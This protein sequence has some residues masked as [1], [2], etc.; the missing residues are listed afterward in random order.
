[1]QNKSKN[2]NLLLLGTISILLGCGYFFASDMFVPSLPHMTSYFSVDSGTARLTLSTFLISLAFSQLLYGPASDRFGRKPII[3]IGII[4]YI[5]GSIV[6]LTSLSMNMLLIGRIVQGLGVGAL[7][8]LSRT[9]IQDSTTKEQFV[10]LVSILSIFFLIA[11]A[12]APLLGGILQTY[13]DWRASFVFMLIFGLSLFLI[14][15]LLLKETHKHKNPKALHL[16]SLHTNYSAILKNIDFLVMC[17]TMV[18]GLAGL[19]VFYT[20]GPFLLTNKYHVSPMTFGIFSVVIVSAAILGRIISSTYLMKHYS[21][22]KILILGLILMFIGSIILIISGFTGTSSLFIIIFSMC[23]YSIGGCLVA[24]IA[25]TNALSMFPKNAGA[26]GAMY[27]FLQMGG[28]FVSSYFAAMVPTSE[29]DLA[30][31]LFILSSSAL[32]IFYTRRAY[33]TNTKN[34]R[35]YLSS[36][37][38]A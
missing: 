3:L 14:I 26:G 6:C 9:I 13:F 32:I 25:S 20:I 29:I 1:M 27:G 11:P 38:A 7:M 23:F 10:K 24:P 17:Y 37:K 21:T 12:S 33:V 8:T 30:I 16:N 4:I 36:H 35:N 34:N 28:L 5:I 22:E 2:H 15:T 18:A 19:V 31:I